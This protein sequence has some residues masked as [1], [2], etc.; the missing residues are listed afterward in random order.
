MDRSDIAPDMT[1]PRLKANQCEM[2][3]PL[4]SLSSRPVIDI[5]ALFYAPITFFTTCMVAA[6][7]SWTTS[8]AFFTLASAAG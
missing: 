7:R 1:T 5:P 3:C 4:L 6:W 8:M 2:Q